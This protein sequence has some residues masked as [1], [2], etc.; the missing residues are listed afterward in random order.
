MAIGAQANFAD[1]F[2]WL[3]AAMKNL[4][5]GKGIKV[6]WPSSDTPE[7]SAE[8]EDD[9]EGEGG[10]DGTTVAFTGTDQSQ[11]I[12]G[13]DFTF[14][15]ATDSNVVVTCEDDVITLGVYYT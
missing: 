6:K 8:G 9:G 3:V 10:G 12:R 15:S 4:K 2:N 13:T 7:I 11:T 14:A 5:G 1:T